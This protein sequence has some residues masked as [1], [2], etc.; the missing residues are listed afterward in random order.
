MYQYVIVAVSD[1]NDSITSSSNTDSAKAYDHIPPQKVYLKTVS[2]TE[3]NKGVTISWAPSPSWDVKNYYIYRKSFVTGNLKFVDST[4]QTT[5]IDSSESVTAPDCY[6]VFARDHCGNQS[7]GSNNGCV[8][9]LSA[10]NQAGYN[11]LEWNGYQTWNDGVQNYNVYKKE[12]SQGWNMIGTTTSGTVHDFTDRNLGDSTITFCYQVEAVENPGKY[13]QLSR[14]TVT[15]IHQ[16][17]TV[18]IPNTFSHYNLDGLNDYFG[19]VG[20]Y[21]KNYTMQIY[22]RWGEQVYKTGKGKPWD[23]TFQGQNTQQG[24]YIYI[25]TVEDYNGNVYNFKG[26]ITIY[27]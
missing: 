15:C 24:I 27:Q 9:I 4:N 26:N 20:L 11:D 14:S 6:Y 3:P 17:A 5:Y 16:N 22:N 7:D 8:I 23:G 18:F 25:I 2:V 19:P 12:D 21:I 1:A 13:N 10:Q